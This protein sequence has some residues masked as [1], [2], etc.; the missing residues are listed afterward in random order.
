MRSGVEVD[1]GEGGR[2]L[3]EERRKTRQRWKGK[4]QEEKARFGVGRKKGRARRRRRRGGREENAGLTKGRT[5]WE[6]RCGSLRPTFYQLPRLYNHCG[7]QARATYNTYVPYYAAGRRHGGRHM[8]H[9]CDYHWAL[10]PDLGGL[11]E[12]SHCLIF[13]STRMKMSLLSLPCYAGSPPSSVLRPPSPARRVLST[14]QPAPVL[15]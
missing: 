3:A 1:A 5:Q 6:G 2:R 11:C 15:H 4:V 13:C 10:D 7:T 12:G 8:Q 14:A 9:C